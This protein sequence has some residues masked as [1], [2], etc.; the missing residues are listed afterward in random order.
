M[1]ISAEL[2]L[3]HAITRIEMDCG[4]LSPCQLI[5]ED[6]VAAVATIR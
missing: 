3:A 5:R 6:E 2:V 1:T 4:A